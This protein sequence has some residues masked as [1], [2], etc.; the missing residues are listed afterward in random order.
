MAH[1]KAAPGYHSPAPHISA[2]CYSF[3]SLQTLNL[4]LLAVDP[5]PRSS[6]IFLPEAL[7]DT[8]PVTDGSGIIPHPLMQ[9]L[10]KQLYSLFHRF[11]IEPCFTTIKPQLNG[12]IFTADLFISNLLY[13]VLSKIPYD[14]YN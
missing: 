13:Q 4:P 5:L 8:L 7:K 12:T 10:I 1:G 14:W 3:L 9:L 2:L 11:A 6:L